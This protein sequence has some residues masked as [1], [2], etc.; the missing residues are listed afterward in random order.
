MQIFDMLIAAVAMAV[1]NC[2]VVSSD[3]DFLAIPGLTVEN[4]TK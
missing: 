3:N 2:T 4:W 1:G